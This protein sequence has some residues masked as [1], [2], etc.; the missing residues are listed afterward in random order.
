MR[1]YV[2]KSISGGE[3]IRR[4]REARGLSQGQLGEILGCSRQR[5]SA[6]ERSADVPSDWI[7]DKLA[8]ALGCSLCSLTEGA[9]YA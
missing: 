4:V 7:L 5:V 8:E 1:R 2:V 3:R 6:I 9:V